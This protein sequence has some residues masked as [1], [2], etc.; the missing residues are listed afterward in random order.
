MKDRDNI[1]WSLKNIID[2]DGCK[3]CFEEYISKEIGRYNK[4]IETT[5]LDLMENGEEEVKEML[6]NVILNMPSWYFKNDILKKMID[7][8]FNEDTKNINFEDLY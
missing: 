1:I 6:T 4:N 3:H 8:K 5:I 7:D 2:D